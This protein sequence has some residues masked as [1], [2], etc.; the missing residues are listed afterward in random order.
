MFEAILKEASTLKRIVDAIKDLVTDVNIDA[1]PQGISL[2]AM[3]SSH[4]ALVSLTLGSQGFERYR[5]DRAMTLGISI[6]NLAKVLKLA[7]NEDRI[8]LKADEE[9]SHLQITF[10]NNSK[11]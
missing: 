2:Q 11:F 10:Q 3:D 9:G 4:V 8:I 7:S 5:A 6:T 1:T